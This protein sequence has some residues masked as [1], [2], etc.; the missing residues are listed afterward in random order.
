[1]LAINARRIWRAWMAARTARKPRRNPETAATIWYERMEKAVARRGWRKLP[2]QTP[3]EF[4]VTIDDPALRDSV[5]RF[6][7]RYERARF[8]D[9][10]DDAEKLP[11]I[12][13]ELKRS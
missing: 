5:A 4:L 2:T 6:T 3:Q 13:E 1:L 7:Q 8:G 10:P 11:Q 12:F 9:S